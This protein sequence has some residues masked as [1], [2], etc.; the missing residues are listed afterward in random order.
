MDVEDMVWY[1][2]AVFLVRHA[3]VKHTVSVVGVSSKQPEVTLQGSHLRKKQVLRQ[4]VELRGGL[5]GGYKER[6]DLTFS[7][8]SCACQG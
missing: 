2:D 8:W 1:S 6:P 5:E 4:E 7:I 3:S